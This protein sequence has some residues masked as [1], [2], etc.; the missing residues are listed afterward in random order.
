MDAGVLFANPSVR[1]L[2]HAIQPFLVVNDNSST[3][4]VSSQ[5]IEDQDRPMVSLSIELVGI[6]LL[7]S[8]WFFPIWAAYYFDSLILLLFVP[9]FHLLSYVVCQRLALHSDEIGD[10]VDKL[11][12]WYYYRWWFLNNMWS[13]NNSYW[14]KHLVGTPFYNSYLRFCGAKIEHHSHIYTTLID[15][16]WL[17]DV[18]ESTFID[19]EVILSSL[20]YQDQT[21]ELHRIQIGSHCSINIRSTM[22]FMWNQCLQSLVT[23]Q[24]RIT[25]YP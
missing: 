17:L 10:R 6:L 16:P 13:I 14:L 7:I 23:L 22:M 25:E 12:S 4:H 24:H 1:Q 18:G 19:E 8:Q 15:T 9:V 20:L 2:A 11:Y 5:L 3:T 21:Y